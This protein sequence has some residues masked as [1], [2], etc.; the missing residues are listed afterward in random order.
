MLNRDQILSAVRSILIALFT[1]AVGKGW[2]STDTA[3]NLAALIIPI[4]IAVWGLFDKTKAN[5]VAK[6]ADIVPIPVASQIAV[7]IPP[8]KVQAIPSNPKVQT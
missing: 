6:A 1:F 5:T 8:D 2:I 4:G 3:A 7:G